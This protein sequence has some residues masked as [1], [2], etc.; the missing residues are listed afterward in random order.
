MY[1]QTKCMHFIMHCL[2]LKW[3]PPLL[4][5]EN[6]YENLRDVKLHKV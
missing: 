6:R 4:G 5:C 1:K 2:A 3:L